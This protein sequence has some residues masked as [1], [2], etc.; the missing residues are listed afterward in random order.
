MKCDLPLG[1]VVARLLAFAEDRAVL[2]DP[3]LEEYFGRDYAAVIAAS[4][5][6]NAGKPAGTKIEVID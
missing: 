5:Q 3:V 4:P 6:H 1:E 2:P